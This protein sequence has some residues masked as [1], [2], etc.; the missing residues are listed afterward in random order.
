MEVE[1]E[2]DLWTN[3]EK[4]FEGLSTNHFKKNFKALNVIRWIFY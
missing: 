1:D 4:K 2:V 3:E